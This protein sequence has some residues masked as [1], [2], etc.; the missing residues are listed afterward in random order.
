MSNLI[1][2]Y[3]RKLFNFNKVPTGLAIRHECIC[4]FEVGADDF[5]CTSSNSER[6]KITCK[7]EQL[8]KRTCWCP[9]PEPQV[10]P[11]KCP[12]RQEVE[13]N[14]DLDILKWLVSKK[15]WP[16]QITEHEATYLEVW[17]P[18]FE[19]GS[20]VGRTETIPKYKCTNMPYSGRFLVPPISGAKFQ[21][22]LSEQSWNVPLTSPY[23]V[24]SPNKASTNIVEPHK[25]DKVIFGAST[26]YHMVSISED[27]S[28]IK[29]SGL[30]KAEVM[31][32]ELKKT[33]MK[34]SG[35]KDSEKKSSMKNYHRKKDS[36]RKDSERSVPELHVR[37]KG[38]CPKYCC[39]AFA[40]ISRLCCKSMGGRPVSS[41]EFYLA[42]NVLRRNETYTD[43]TDICKN[44]Q[45][46][47]SEVYKKFSERCD[48]KYLKK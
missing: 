20:N 12:I 37:E 16:I 13:R 15:Y 8:T 2:G 14:S 17:P 40:N 46:L 4:I 45:S 18:S 7:T 36:E 29:E 11:E 39:P 34:D 24:V 30:S 33:L 25:A 41:V 9:G 3:F 21:K 42:R 1:P 26:V 23:L 44:L 47:Y 27:D 43:V 35:Q 22:L 28:E 32:F 19:P 48:P 6:R 10:P 31:F 5:D 38:S